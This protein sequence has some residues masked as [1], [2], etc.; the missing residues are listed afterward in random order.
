[1]W[2]VC[3]S[4]TAVVRHPDR[5]AAVCSAVAAWVA[6]LGAATASATSD[7]QTWPGPDVLTPPATP[8]AA[9]ASAVVTLRGRLDAARDRITTQALPALDTYLALDPPTQ[10]QIVAQ[11]RTHA[12]ILRGLALGVRAMA[13]IVGRRLDTV[14]D[15]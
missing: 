13:R 11:V 1:M 6:H 15:D 7:E 14:E 5:H 10:A 4:C 12:L 8:G 9:D 3:P 2:A